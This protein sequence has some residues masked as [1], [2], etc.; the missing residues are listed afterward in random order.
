MMNLTP[1]PR[2]TLNAGEAPAPR[3]CS[4]GC[5]RDLRVEVV[6]ARCPECLGIFCGECYSYGH[7]CEETR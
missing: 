2:V 1:K 4:G 3:L 5:L 7:D 6:C